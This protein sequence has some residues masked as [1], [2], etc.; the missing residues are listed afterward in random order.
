MEVIWMTE[1]KFS[2]SIP[3]AVCLPQM[4]PGP[5]TAFQ[6]LQGQSGQIP[7]RAVLLN[8]EH[9]DID[10]AIAARSEN[11]VYIQNREGELFKFYTKTGEKL[12]FEKGITTGPVS[13]SCVSSL[14]HVLSIGYELWAFDFFSPTGSIIATGYEMRAGTTRLVDPVGIE[15]IWSLGSSTIS[16]NADSFIVGGGLAKGRIDRYSLGGEFLKSYDFASISLGTGRTIIGIANAQLRLDGSIIATDG[17]SV[18]HLSPDG[19][20]LG[21]FDD[22]VFDDMGL[23]LSE[24]FLIDENETIWSFCIGS[25]GRKAVLLA[26]SLS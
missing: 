25:E 15:P 22:F 12:F 5:G 10:Y 26:V 13:Q 7:M 8:D 6:L 14:G 9:V 19:D 4:V 16:A 20:V 23:M 3:G 17:F 11:E 1:L 21:V 2:S 18:I 24:M